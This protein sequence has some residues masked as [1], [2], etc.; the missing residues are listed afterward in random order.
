MRSKGSSVDLQ[1]HMVRSVSQSLSAVGAV[2]TDPFRMCQWERTQQD[3]VAWAL[4]VFDTSAY[5]CRSQRG[6]L[7]IVENIVARCRQTEWKQVINWLAVLSKIS[8]L[9]KGRMVIVHVLFS[10]VDCNSIFTL[11][12]YLRTFLVLCQKSY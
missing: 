4:I 3:T 12:L 9:L 11:L 2:A 7:S 6:C 5:Q 1:S 10:I 8:A